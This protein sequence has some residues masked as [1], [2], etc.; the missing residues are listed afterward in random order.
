MLLIGSRALAMYYPEY[1]KDRNIIDWDFICTKNEF[2]EL[3]SN[4]IQVGNRLVKISFEEG[5]NK[6]FA[7]FLNK[8]TN[9]AEIIEVS[10]VDVEG[11]LQE[12]DIEVY[13]FHHQIHESFDIMGFNVYTLVASVNLLYVLKLSHKYKKNSVHFEKTMQDIEFLSKKK[14]IIEPLK[15]LLE[16]RERLTYNYGHPKLNTSKKEFF[17]DSVPYQYDHDTIHEAV[18]HLDHP[19]YTYYMKDGEQVLCS[20]EKFFALPEIVRLYGVLEESYV[21]ALER[22]IIPYDTDPDRA[23]KIALEKVCTSITSGWFREFAYENY[24]KV[25]SLYHSSFVN[26]FQDALQRGTIKPYNKST[27]Y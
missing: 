21:L 5:T 13:N 10:F 22:A 1:T 26:K 14:L 4:L 25:K 27:S 11:G 17:T 9:E 6:A 20:K 12:S 23:F 7:C 2:K 16:N 3:V 8:E 24:H 15:G 19:A 18:K